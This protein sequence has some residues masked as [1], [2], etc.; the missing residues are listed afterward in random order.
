MTT[1]Y[2]IVLILLLSGCGNGGGIDPVGHDNLATSEQPAAEEYQDQEE[3]M[4]DSEDE[5]ASTPVMVTAS[6]LTECTLDQNKV[7]CN[8]ADERFGPE[9]YNQIKIF[10]SN[11]NEIPSEELEFTIVAQRLIVEPKGETSIRSIKI[12]E[13]DVALSSDE[14]EDP[15]LEG[16]MSSDDDT[17]ALPPA[18]LSIVIAG[19]DEFTA[20]PSVSLPLNSS[21]HSEMYV[22]N[23]SDCLSG[24]E[25]E[26]YAIFKNWDLAAVEGTTS[27]FVKFRDE[28]ANESLCVSDSIFL[29]T[30]APS[31]VAAIDDGLF[32]ASTADSPVMS[33]NAATDSGSGISHYEFSTGTSPGLDDI[34]NWQNIGTSTSTVFNDLSLVSRQTYYANIRAVDI[35]GNIGDVISG[36]GFIYNFCKSISVGGTWVLVPGDVN[37]NASDFCLMKYEAKDNAG[38]PESRSSN[39]PWNNISQDEARTECASLGAGYHILTNP[40]WMTVANNAASVAS[41]WSGNSVGSGELARGHSD[42]NPSEICEADANDANGYVE[43]NCLGATSGDGFDQRRTHTLSNG[44]VIWDLSANVWEWIDYNNANNKPTPNTNAFY[45]YSLPIVGTG[46]MVLTELIPQ[47]AIDNL[48]NSNQSIGQYY[49]GLP[50]DGGAL[51]RGGSYFFGNASGIFGAAMELESSGTGNDIGFR[52]AVDVP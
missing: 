20:S 40:E 42:D 39:K 38:I 45:E 5:G 3:S 4:D 29:D 7:V 19:G 36:D 25:W 15:G 46:V 13:T 12:G 30:Q 41:N 33:W 31:Q 6:F 49:P 22:T 43:G 48:W 18:E 14:E 9:L 28:E 44:E 11:G 51:Y 24:G 52:C 37:Y 17:S 2:Y 35:A 10:D 16:G 47:I 50:G 8:I 32:T 23:T 26:P 27:V 34:R 21:N 1:N